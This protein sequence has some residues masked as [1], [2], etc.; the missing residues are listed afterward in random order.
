MDW[1]TDVVSGNRHHDADS[2]LKDTR[3]ALDAKQSPES[4]GIGFLCGVAQRFAVAAKCV[5][6]GPRAKPDKVLLLRR[7][8]VHPQRA[9]VCGLEVAH[10]GH[11]LARLIGEELIR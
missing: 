5:A 6:E 2:L 10:A 7:A 8:N 3:P 4:I 9:E 11:H 1:G